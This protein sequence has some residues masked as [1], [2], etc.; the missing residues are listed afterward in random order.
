MLANIHG[1]SINDSNP[2]ETWPNAHTMLVLDVMVAES[3][4]KI[5]EMSCNM[6]EVDLYF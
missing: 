3:N 1:T 6:I 5:I 4:L 2:D